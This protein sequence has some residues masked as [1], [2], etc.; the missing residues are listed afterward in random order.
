MNSWADRIARFGD[1]SKLLALLA[2]PD[3]PQ[4]AAEAERLFWMT[5]ASGWFTA[6][7][8][9]DLPDFVPAVNTHLNCIGTNP[10]FIYGTASIDGSGSYLLTGERGDGLFLLMDVTAGGL[11]VTDELGPSLG[12][13]DFDTLSL[14]DEGRFSLL[15][16]AEKPADWT[17][18]WRRLD[19]ATRSLS[20]RQASY[21]WGKGR[22]ARIAIERTDKAHR[23]RYW[24]EEQIAERLTALAAYPARLSAM[25]MGFIKAQRDKGLWN[26][27]EHDDW[28][29]KGGVQGQHYY[30]GLFRL[31][32]GQVLLLET[33]LPDTVRYWNVQLSDMLWNSIDW[34]NRQSSLNG[35]QAHIDADGKFRAVIAREDPG[36]PNW[37]DTGGNSEGAIMLRWNEASSG[38][39]PVLR[40]IDQ[41]E[42]HAHLPGD[43]PKVS[44]ELRDE[45]LRAR[46]RAVQYRRRW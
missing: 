7:A 37:L 5:L 3:D 29:G 15:L 1:T 2:N 19:P 34:M 31:E 6:F 40:L 22:E 32:P 24:S 25:A 11:G 16:S 43:M 13:L 9:P 46:R 12:T 28:A 17:G 23:P 44:P 21:D 30:Q 27:L 42:L 45:Q 41:A 14:D 4:A 26:A 33:G 20:L 8:D 35:G 39:V 36:V 18:D 10:D 38:P